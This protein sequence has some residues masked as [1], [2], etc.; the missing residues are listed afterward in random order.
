MSEAEFAREGLKKLLGR[1][2][3]LATNDPSWDFARVF[4][5]VLLSADHQANLVLSDTVETKTLVLRS[6]VDAT[7]SE[8]KS[9][10]RPVG[11]VLINAALVQ[12]LQVDKNSSSIPTVQ[13]NEQQKQPV[14]D[15]AQSIAQTV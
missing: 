4:V 15:Q 14:L 13:S 8:E 11:L 7:L 9:F 1:R 6:A 12:S 3:R 2:V 10:D 5:G